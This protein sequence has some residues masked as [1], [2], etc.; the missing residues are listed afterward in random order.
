MISNIICNLCLIT[1]IIKLL[2]IIIECIVKNI[3]RCWCYIRVSM[4]LI[5]YANI[6]DNMSL[7]SFPVI[8]IFMYFL[9]D[10]ILARFHQSVFSSIY[11][12]LCYKKLVFPHFSLHQYYHFYLS[13]YLR[14]SSETTVSKAL[15]SLLFNL[16]YHLQIPAIFFW[17]VM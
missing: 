6:T 8:Y 10:F 9:L 16:Q 12:P 5:K 14:Y 2:I 4:I 7:D 13:N 15:Y 11:S 17:D 1:G 3:A